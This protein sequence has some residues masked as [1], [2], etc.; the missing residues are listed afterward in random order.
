MRYLLALGAAALT[1]SASGAAFAAPAKPAQAPQCVT[2]GLPTG[3]QRA[4]GNR[5]VF[6]R[7]MATVLDAAIDDF[8]QNGAGDGLQVFCVTNKANDVF[9]TTAMCLTGES[10]PWR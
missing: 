3:V 2:S 9:G 1:L 8:G 4:I 10:C 5:V 7:P 6:V